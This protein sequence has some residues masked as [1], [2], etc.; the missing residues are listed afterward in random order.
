MLLVAF[1]PPTGKN[2]GNWIRP[3]FF[4]RGESVETT[5]E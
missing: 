3:V 1:G 5:E 4:V 2:S